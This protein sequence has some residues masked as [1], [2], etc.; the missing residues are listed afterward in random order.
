MANHEVGESMGSA[1]VRAGDEPRAA[2]DGWSSAPGG[3]VRIG[4]SD[5]TTD[6]GDPVR[7]YRAL[8]QEAGHYDLAGCGLVHVS[9]DGA[10]ALVQ[11]VLT[12]DVQYLLPEACLTALVVDAGGVVVDVVTVFARDDGSFE[13]QTSLGAGTRTGDAV[14]AGRGPSAAV[15]IV[16]GA[17]STVAIEGPL[18]WSV[19][20]KLGLEHVID[21]PFQAVRS[22]TLGG[23]RLRVSRTGVTGEFG[24]QLTG[25]P[26]VVDA[27]QDDLA[28]LC[29][30]VGLTALEATMLDVRHPVPWRECVG[31]EVVRAGLQWLV[32]H[33]KDGYRGR[34]AI[35]RQ[36]EAPSTSRVGFVAR[37]PGPAAG[38]TAAR[39]PVRAADEVVGEVV[40]ST[41]SPGR[42]AV[43]GI[44]EL[45][46][47][48][49]VPSLRLTV[50][51]S[52][53]PVAIETLSS[54]MVVPGSW[55]VVAAERATQFADAG[56]KHEST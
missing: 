14:G 8:R 31:T 30:R 56:G 16:V 26:E 48:I 9:G 7:E 1:D 25:R 47:D 36:A 18:T 53:G 55:A 54:P 39:S 37:E 2:G 28:R 13:L 50:D 3:H 46:H 27:L 45:L 38:R 19:L 15:D 24:V 51:G 42:G 17:P 33:Q 32:D 4:D 40:W 35:L 41:Y 49:G 23:E 11:H 44:V 43:V 5:V 29:P 21:L 34:D 22:T 12:R 20:E 6:H 10:L 52:G